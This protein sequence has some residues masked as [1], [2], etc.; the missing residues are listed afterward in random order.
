MQ[1]FK[2]FFI[3]IYTIVFIFYKK[4]TFITISVISVMEKRGILYLMI[5]SRYK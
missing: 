4:V 2:I 5:D 3:V 1:I